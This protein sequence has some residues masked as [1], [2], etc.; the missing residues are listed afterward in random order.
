MKHLADQA[1]DLCEEIDRSGDHVR[2]EHWVCANGEQGRTSIP[3]EVQNLMADIQRIDQDSDDDRQTF[4]E[5]ESDSE[6][7]A[8]PDDEEETDW[9][10]VAAEEAETT[11]GP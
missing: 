10:E 9:S 8:A 4:H 3:R 11:D 7:T 2:A 1:W 6:Q 5:G